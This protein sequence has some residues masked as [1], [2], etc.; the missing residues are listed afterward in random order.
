MK[1]QPKLKDRKVFEINLKGFELEYFR[2]NPVVFL[3]GDI[4]KPPV[5][6]AQYI[7]NSTVAV[8]FTHPVLVDYLENIKI[9]PAYTVDKS[10]RKIL[11]N[12]NA[13][14]VT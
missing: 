13:R 7:N 11:R 1:P 6:I 10:G 14:I 3:D 12:L 2:K 8:V 9:S 4:S 5:G